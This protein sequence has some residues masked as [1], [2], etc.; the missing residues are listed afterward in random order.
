MRRI[1]AALLG[2]VL[3]SSILY[4]AP[5][6]ADEPTTIVADR[7][8]LVK[9]WQ[10]GGPEVKSEAAVALAGT[11]DQVIAFLSHGYEL[12]QGI[13]ERDNIASIMVEGG[14][15]VRAAAQQALAAA[16]TGSTFA[17]PQFFDHGWQTA[18]NIDLRL[19]VDQL[20]ATGGNQVREAAQQ[21]LDSED[22]EAL[23]RFLDS[24]WQT[25]FQTDERLQVN[26]A[27]ATGGPEVQATAQKALDDGS[28]EA[29][30]QFLSYGWEVA[31]ARDDETE[32]LT[33][34][35]AQA[36][37]NEQI[38]EKETKDAKA[39]AQRA[40]EGAAAA[41]RA[42]QE[43][44]AAAADARND[45]ARAATQAKRAATAAR[46]AAEAAQV[47]VSAAA[48]ANR[49]A[50]HASAAA[51]RA[52]RAAGKA[53]GAASK[54]FKAAALAGL[55]RNTVQNARVI[56]QQA[57]DAAQAAE[58]LAH[59][60]G[61]AAE[62]VVA[63]KAAVD[64]IKEAAKQ[65]K[66][67]ADANNE[68][69]GYARATG[70]DTTEAVQAAKVAQ[71]AADRANRAAATAGRYMQVAIDCAYAARDAA[72]DTAADARRAAA[73]A[74]NAADHAVDATE[75]ANRAVTHAKS[76]TDAAVKVV[77]LAA[78]AQKVH[79][80][81][82]DAESE[83]L[84]VA[85]D[86]AL[87]A[88][89][90]GTTA[91]EQ[92]LKQT[93]WDTQQAVQRDAE[94]KQLIIQAQDPQTAHG[95]AV[96]AARRAALSLATANGVWTRQGAVDA[97]GGDE[98]EILDFIRVGLP[99]AEAQDDRIA[100]TDLT[101]STDAKLAAAA[102]AVLTGTDAQVSEFL[103]TQNYAGRYSQDRTKV[104]QVLFTARGAGRTITAQRAQAALDADTLPAL[105]EFLGTGQYTAGAIDDR[106]TANQIIADP[107]SGPEVVAA[108]QVALDGPPL[109][110]QTF[111]DTGRYVA[112]ERDHD[113]LL[114]LSV[115]AGLLERINETAATAAQSA[116]EAQSAAARAQGDGAAANNY[117]NQAI[118]SAAAAAT[119]ANN[120]KTSAENAAASAANA[121]ASAKTA[122]NAATRANASA[123][124]AI[125]SANWAINSRQQAIDAA[126]AAG[127]AAE[128]AKNLA[129]AAGGDAEA[130]RQAAGAAYNEW[131]TGFANAMEAC[132]VIYRT[133]T[134]NN[135]EDFFDA[136]KNSSYKACVGNA[137]GDPNE[138]AN[139]SYVN[140][141]RCDGLYPQGSQLHSDCVHNTLNP[142]FQWMQQ[143]EFIG[144][145]ANALTAEAL[146]VLAGL[147]GICVVTVV[148]AAIVGNLIGLGDMG[149]NLYRLIKGDQSLA[150]TLLHLGK[151]AAETLAFNGA[152]KLLSV[153]FRGLKSLYIAG[154]SAKKAKAELQASN[155]TRFSLSRWVGCAARS[156]NSFS[157]ETPVLLA[158]GTTEPIARVKPGD[159]VLATDPQTG[160][161]AGEPVVGLITS[162]DTEFTDVTVAGGGLL[163]TTTHHPF[164]NVT[165]KAWVDAG[166]LRLGTEVAT[167][168]GHAAVLAVRNFTG[169]RTMHNLTVANLHTY[170][171]FAGG[172]A[173]LVHN[174]PLDPECTH[175]VLGLNETVTG[176]GS[177]ALR[178]LLIR[179]HGIPAMT[180]NG[181]HTDIDPVN[182]L[183]RWMNSVKS[184]I[185]DP[186][187]HLYITLDGLDG[188]TE[189]MTDAQKAVAKIQTA[190]RNGLKWSREAV[191]RGEKSGTDW[192]LAML[193]G[194]FYDFEGNM[195]RSPQS[196]SWWMNGKD[197]SAE[198]RALLP[199]SE[200]EWLE[201]R[202]TKP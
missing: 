197:I 183:P 24:G 192:E 3:L 125:R 5:A 26:Q 57:L 83:R 182:L 14:P 82:R 120:A 188:A 107:T 180:Y 101:T 176:L 150:E 93:H 148:C 70:A 73:A 92:Q 74:I 76:A 86:E 21:A 10:Q 170:Y 67:A 186:T 156:A 72:L 127:Q 45:A 189:G 151:S 68:A 20:M 46:K 43:A 141:S 36:E 59:K 172:A 112:A 71:A 52:S 41:K 165:A 35:L 42:A 66:V 111:L 78:Q 69:V 168:G 163:H 61:Q 116:Q 11:D 199:K 124:S 178:D 33:G 157:P 179:E 63:G 34:L 105:R 152:A 91:F 80:A 185:N 109:S 184:G 22:P 37:A 130:A 23:Q 25:Q 117:A 160:R 121:I 195:I 187:V 29:L 97:L 153:T 16:D 137:V 30:D 174:S 31:S 99:K 77:D 39:E 134:V 126:T 49:A 142:D 104:N 15:S 40:A 18:A 51:V 8:S 58:D 12:A 75:A 94:T 27:K 50:R 55:D 146:P 159:R 201:F 85:T 114:H 190:V 167:P 161:T 155:L 38:V 140:V 171:V 149:L 102:G 62:A 191:A 81:E 1:L 202:G 132:E 173:V 138:M 106:L 145:I 95:S 133:H 162:T 198:V 108:A 56:A 47:A 164:W 32:T 128:R 84:A 96:V 113:T 115:V 65:A 7:P 193:S 129:L 194:S 143:L 200:D 48:A 2:P 64:N 53:A 144:Q 181:I 158:D 139:R 131:H 100:V 177:D 88:A 28:T 13:D 17:L 175:L 79:D 147:G 119:Y 44:A 110:L 9:I 19:Q 118:A 196:V 136:D 103:R 87:E 122:K 4:A 89:R 54:A 135:F 166:S 60:A 154:I 98:D 90:E 169:N 123:R 6:Y